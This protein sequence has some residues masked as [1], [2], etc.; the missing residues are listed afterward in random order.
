MKY[1]PSSIAT[2]DLDIA[3]APFLGG[4]FAVYLTNTAAVLLGQID[5]SAAATATFTANQGA[6]IPV[7][8]GDL[9]VVAIT[10]VRSAADVQIILDVTDENDE[11]DTA[12][13]TFTAAARAA[14]QSSHFPRGVAMD[15]A[16]VTG[17]TGATKVKT[18]T[19]L[20]SVVG[21]DANISFAV[22]L[23]PEAAD[24]SLVGCTTG[25][26]F[27]TKSRTPIGVDCGMETDAFIKRGK[28][29]AGELSIDAKFRGLHDSLAR[30]DGK[31]CTALLVGVK[32]GVV[33]T[34]RI[35][36]T[37]YVPSVEVDL[38][39]ADGEAMES[40]ASGK[41]AEHLFFTAP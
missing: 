14:N 28:T 16:L 18:I 2:N 30:F 9:C 33:L 19:G 41:F 4:E 36:F 29:K 10:E 40:A 24:Y 11:A 12:A 8:G 6:A 13:A 21:G 23:L 32:D 22:Y 20:D 7:T 31:K 1:V 38:P 37:Q 35:V 5:F 15:L 17:A 27:N 26:K 34:D 3:Q 39:D 25:K